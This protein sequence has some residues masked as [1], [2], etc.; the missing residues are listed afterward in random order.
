[1]KRLSWI[2]E[3]MTVK[4]GLFNFQ[5]AARTDKAVSAVAQVD[6]VIFQMYSWLHTPLLACQFLPIAHCR[7]YNKKKQVFF[8]ETFHERENFPSNVKMKSDFVKIL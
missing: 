1:M 8:H 6:F 2:S 7:V 5:R 4:P 3:E